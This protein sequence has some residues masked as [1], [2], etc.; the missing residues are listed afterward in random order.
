MS[1]T[2]RSGPGS[3]AS[4]QSAEVAASTPASAA[5]IAGRRS[6]ARP[7]ASRSVRRQRPSPASQRC[8]AVVS[9]SAFSVTSRSVGLRD[10]HTRC[11]R[12]GRSFRVW[13]RAGYSSKPTSTSPTRASP[14][15]RQ[16][17]SPNRTGVSGTR[18]YE[19][20]CS[21]PRYGFTLASKPMSGLLLVATIVR[22]GSERRRVSGLASASAAAS[23]ALGT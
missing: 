10:V 3:I 13:P 17:R 7:G 16:P 14:I 1:T 22:E 12:A 2:S 4:I 19:H 15:G 21:Q 11:T 6:R 18:Q 5:A 20:A 23:A 9:T 8:S